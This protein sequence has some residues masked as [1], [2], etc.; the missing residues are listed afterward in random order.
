MDLTKEAIKHIQE[1]A[2]EPE[3]R[4]VY[5]DG[6]SFFVNDRGEFHEIDIQRQ[7]ALETHTLKS[8][9]DFIKNVDHGYKKLIIHIKNAKEV[10]L[11]SE[12]EDDEQRTTLMISNAIL[13]NIYLETFLS[14]ENMN[15]QLQSKFDYTKDKEIILKVLGNLKGENVTQYGDDGVSQ[16][17][18]IKSGVTTLSEVK[19]QNP[20]LLKPF[21]TFREVEQ[22]RSL[23][24]FRMQEGGKSA[25]FEA[26]GESYRL[27]AIKNIRKYFEEELEEYSDVEISIIG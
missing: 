14:V 11:L 27:D 16:K 7:K 6:R 5:A 13:P 17:V 9:V 20:A 12:L 21:R 2:I 10:R 4:L 19:V 26:D 23:Y 15:I 3:S 22:P 25:L 8:I 1:T 18:T 24:V